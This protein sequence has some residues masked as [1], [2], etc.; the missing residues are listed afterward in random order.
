MAT[1]VTIGM[2]GLSPEDVMAVAL[3]GAEVVLDPKAEKEVRESFVW[4]DDLLRP[5]AVLV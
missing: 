5:R 4:S 3:H 1:K 2:G